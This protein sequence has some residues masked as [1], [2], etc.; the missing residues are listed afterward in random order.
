MISSIDKKDIVVHLAASL[1]VRNTEENNYRCYQINVR[2]TEN[3]LDICLQKGIKK[4]I[5]ASSSEVYGEPLTNPISEEFKTYPKSIYAQTKL[6][7][8]GLVI[9]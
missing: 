2:G 3:V 9:L 8:E 4:F 7:G 1:G 6:M 5:Y